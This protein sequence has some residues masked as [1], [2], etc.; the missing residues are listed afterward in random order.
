MWIQWAI[1][2]LTRW[3]RARQ[4]CQERLAEQPVLISG[5][6]CRGCIVVGGKRAFSDS[7]ATQVF[8]CSNF[9]IAS[10]MVVGIASFLLSGA[11]PQP[12]SVYRSCQN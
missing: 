11:S 3:G 2:L 9:A 10:L 6:I 5:A 4:Y 8:S 7:A 12:H 1:V